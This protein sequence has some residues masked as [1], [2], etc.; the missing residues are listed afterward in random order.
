MQLERRDI[1]CAVWGVDH[2][3]NKRYDVGII[4]NAGATRRAIGR[5]DRHVNISHGIVDD[6]MPGDGRLICT[7]AEV[8]D[9]WG[10][11]VVINQPI[12]TDYWYDAGEDRRGLVFY[13]YRAPDAFS[14]P[15]VADAL[16]VPFLWLRNVRHSQARKVLRRAALV[17]ASGRAA[18]EA[19]ACGAP[20]LICS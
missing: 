19:M 5:C 12:D 17:C 2:D 3:E 13:S 1:E 6:E 11:G 7:S 14:L 4:A 9:R 18:L 15:A 8:A 10:G 20:T 16:G